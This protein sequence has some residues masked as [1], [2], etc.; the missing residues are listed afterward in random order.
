MIPDVLLNIVLDYLGN[1]EEM[2]VCVALNRKFRNPVVPMLNA[3]SYFR[4]SGSIETTQ[5]DI[6]T[7]Y[8]NANS[9]MTKIEFIN[10]RRVPDNTMRSLEIKTK[11]EKLTLYM[12]GCISRLD[13]LRINSKKIRKLTIFADLL[14]IAEIKLVSKAPVYSLDIRTIDDSYHHV[15]GITGFPKLKQFVYTNEHNLTDVKFD[16]VPDLE[17]LYEAGGISALQTKNFRNLRIFMPALSHGY[18]E[19]I[20]EEPEFGKLQLCIT[21]RLIRHPGFDRI[22]DPFDMREDRKPLPDIRDADRTSFGKMI[23]DVLQDMICSYLEPLEQARLVCAYDNPKLIRLK[24]AKSDDSVAEERNKKLFTDV[25]LFNDR[26]TLKLWIS[27]NGVNQ[28]LTVGDAKHKKM[29]AELFK[30]YKTDKKLELDYPYNHQ[31]MTLIIDMK[32]F[33][34][35]DRLAK[36]DVSGIGKLR[37]YNLIDGQTIPNLKIPRLSLSDFR[38]IV[39]PEHVKELEIDHGIPIINH[40][41]DKL[42]FGITHVSIYGKQPIYECKTLELTINK[43]G[44]AGWMSIKVDHAEHLILRSVSDMCVKIGRVPEMLKKITLI[45]D[46]PVLSIGPNKVR[47]LVL[48]NNSYDIPDLCVFPELKTLEVN[49]F[50]YKHELDLDELIVNVHCVKDLRNVKCRILVS[51]SEVT[52]AEPPRVVLPIS[53]PLSKQSKLLA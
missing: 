48:K 41:L 49:K 16:P 37:L 23:P 6:F 7:R 13:E 4:K 27:E 15:L 32:M 44:T 10:D 21:D 53:V 39:I 25:S 51:E 11:C 36:M 24:D 46:F 35:F 43:L 38:E 42:A 40:K 52:L 22:L 31:E 1:F 50:S 47:H 20:F 28:V 9:D 12:C 3:N 26:L 34:D 14:C 33:T 17:E 30:K 19:S 29:E 5:V 2:R 8:F 18:S 45:G